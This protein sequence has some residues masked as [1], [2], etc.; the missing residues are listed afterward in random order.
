MQAIKRLLGLAVVALGLALGSPEAGANTVTVTVGGTS[1]TLTPRLLSFTGNAAVLQAQPWWGNEALAFAIS[2]QLQY[3]LGD[4]E[5]GP[6]TSPG[7]PSVLLAYGTQAGSVSI[8]F[9][10]GGPVDC[11]V[12]CPALSDPFFYATLGAATPIPTLSPWGLLL[13]CALMGVVGMVVTR[14]VRSRT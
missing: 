5:G 12:G 8:T 1:Y 9:W 14:R 6:G 11:P 13:A 2:S 10:D 4:L 7:I 3:Q